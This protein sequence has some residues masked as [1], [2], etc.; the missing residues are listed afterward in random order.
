LFSFVMFLITLRLIKSIAGCFRSARRIICA[1]AR[2]KSVGERNDPPYRGNGRS[3]LRLVRDV[4]R[5][6]PDH[7]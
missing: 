2:R 1:P 3:D 6:R 5:T 4:Y 7:E